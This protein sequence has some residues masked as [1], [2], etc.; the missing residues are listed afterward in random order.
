MCIRCAYGS[1]QRYLGAR[2][3]TYPNISDHQSIFVDVSGQVSI[4]MCGL[5]SVRYADPF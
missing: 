3:P 5:D 4:G 1:Q 2:V